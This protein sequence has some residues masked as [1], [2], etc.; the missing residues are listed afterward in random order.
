MSLQVVIELPILLGKQSTYILNIVRNPRGDVLV[1]VL[2]GLVIILTGYILDII[3]FSAL[4]IFM[5]SKQAWYMS[6]GAHTMIR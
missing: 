1:M 4:N 3:R 5:T 6:S 2:G